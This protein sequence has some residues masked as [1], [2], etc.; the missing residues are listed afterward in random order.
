[1]APP[2]QKLEIK[3]DSDSMRAVKGLTR[4]LE[5]QNAI[6]IEVERERRVMHGGS[7]TPGPTIEGDYYDEGTLAKVHEALHNSGIPLEYLPDAISAMQNGGILF[8][9]RRRD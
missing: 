5:Q 8:R 4:A 1:V 7:T 9:E 6:A 2:P 3:F